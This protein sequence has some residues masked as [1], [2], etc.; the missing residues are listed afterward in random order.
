M[1]GAEAQ[2]LMRGCERSFTILSQVERREGIFLNA[3]RRIGVTRSGTPFSA[4][5][6]GSRNY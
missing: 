2:R 6:G 5:L 1:D 4:D 3:F